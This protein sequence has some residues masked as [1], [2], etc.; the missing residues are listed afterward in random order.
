[1]RGV[2]QV[3]IPGNLSVTDLGLEHLAASRVV[4]LGG[5]TGIRGENLMDLVYRHGQLLSVKWRGGFGTQWPFVE[6][7]KLWLARQEELGLVVEQW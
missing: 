1:M 6:H 7:V 3:A 2:E 5:C 4:W